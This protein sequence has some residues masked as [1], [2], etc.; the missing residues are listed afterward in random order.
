MQDNDHRVR[1]L[2]HS[3]L[4][5]CGLVVKKQLGPHVRSIIGCWFSGMCDPHQPT[6]IMASEAFAA[7]FSPDKRLG[8][9]KFGLKDIVMV[10]WS[11]HC[12]V[13]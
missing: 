8:V 1:E 11:L 7:I 3:A 12:S 2:S 5:S 4:R 9:Y 10:I 13:Q 6:A